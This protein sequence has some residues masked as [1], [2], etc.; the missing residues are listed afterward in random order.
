M[1]GHGN[2][3]KLQDAI[4]RFCEERD[5]CQYH[6]GKDL[7]IAISVEASELLEPFLWKDAS[8]APLRKIKE[9]LAD[10]IIYALLMAKVYDLDVA[11]IVE[12][13][14]RSNDKK[15]PAEKVKGKALKYTEV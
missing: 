11:A 5:W 14:L 4:L 15:Y 6:N 8:A 2:I 7:A 9:E 12:E 13:K 10:V 1:V 3:A